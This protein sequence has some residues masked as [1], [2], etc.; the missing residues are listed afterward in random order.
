MDVIFGV[1]IRGRVQ[2]VG[3]RVWA[4]VTALELGV[5]GW[6]RNCRDGAVEAVFAGS[7]EAV[8]HDRAV[9][10]R[11]ARRAGDSDR[12]AR[13]RS[14]RFGAPASRRFVFRAGHVLSV[15]GCAEQRL[16]GGPERSVNILH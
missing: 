1:V 2:G 16:E 4:E 12:S 5:A 6:I 10:R 9:P 14:R 11:A 8:S 13:G 3:Y 7:E 15:D